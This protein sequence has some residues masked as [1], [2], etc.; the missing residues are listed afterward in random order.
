[1]RRITVSTWHTPFTTEEDRTRS[2]WD[3]AAEDVGDVEA[4]LVE[5][6]GP[7]QK[8]EEDGE[9]LEKAKGE[10]WELERGRRRCVQ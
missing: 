3:G 2:R 8:G 4:A 9:T 1:M 5:E 7:P 10:E 6:A